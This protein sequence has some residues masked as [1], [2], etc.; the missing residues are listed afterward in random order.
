VTGCV[1]IAS[2]LAVKVATPLAFN[3][4][5]PSVV[6]PSTKVTVPAGMPFGEVTVAVKVT[7]VPVA[8]GEAVVARAVVVGKK[9]IVS[10]TVFDVEPVNALSPTYTAVMLCV[11]VVSALVEKAATPLAFRVPLPSVVEPSRN[12]TAPVGSAPLLAPPMAAVNV[13]LV[14]IPTAA[15]EV[16][17]TFVVAVG[18]TITSASNGELAARKAESPLY[19]ANRV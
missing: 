15:A 16:V 12:V 18:V 19:C 9:P 4:P 17:S 7:G 6:V 14:P 3:V 8:V 10:V 13:T 11:P 5:V 1:P 2:A